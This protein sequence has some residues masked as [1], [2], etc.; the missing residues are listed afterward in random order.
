[1]YYISKGLRQ[2]IYKKHDDME[3]LRQIALEEGMYNMRASGWHKVVEGSTTVD[4]VL[5]ATVAE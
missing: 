2:G 4:E 1:V 5:E 3:Y